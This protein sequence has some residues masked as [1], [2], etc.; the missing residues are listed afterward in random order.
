MLEGHRT[1]GFVTKGQFIVHTERGEVP[2]VV[3]HWIGKVFTKLKG[4]EICLGLVLKID[5]LYKSLLFLQRGVLV[6]SPICHCP[7]VKT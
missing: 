3:K 5:G 7:S 1:K 2:P 6:S 4:K